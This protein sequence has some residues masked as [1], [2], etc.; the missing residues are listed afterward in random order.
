[1]FSERIVATMTP[2]HMIENMTIDNIVSF[3]IS[4]VALLKSFVLMW[5]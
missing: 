1:M 2:D 3:V 5:R 4:L